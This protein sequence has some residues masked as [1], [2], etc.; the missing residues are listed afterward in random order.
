MLA[1]LVHPIT[2]I[3]WTQAFSVITPPIFAIWF[4]EHISVLT[5]TTAQG[6]ASPPYR[7]RWRKDIRSGIRQ[8]WFRRAR[9]AD[10]E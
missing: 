9:T 7:C 2:A 4:H 10:A 6:L 8:Q 3:L 5:D 1:G